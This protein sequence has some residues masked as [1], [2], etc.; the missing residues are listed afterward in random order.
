MAATLCERADAILRA[1]DPA[2]KVA[3]S[4]Q[5]AAAWRA[6]EIAEIGRATPP[7]RPAR[8]GRPRLLAPREMPKRRAAGSRAGRVAL[9]HALVHIELNAI[10]LA[11]D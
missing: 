5:T 4:H 9:L 8:P 6:G 3:L 10:D 2:D 1:P 7:D 11:W